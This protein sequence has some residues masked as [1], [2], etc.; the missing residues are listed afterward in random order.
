MGRRSWPFAFGIAACGAG[1]QAHHSIA[2]VYDSTR[3]VTV[4]GRVTEFR[5]VN[6]H[7]FLIIEAADGVGNPQPWQLEMDNRFELAQIGITGGTYKPGDLVIATGSAGRE[8][9]QSLYVRRLD[10]PADGLRYEQI[11][12]R[13]RVS[14]APP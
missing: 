6:P 3:Q 11:G 4:E 10:R 2:S 7:P 5:F 8:Q 9:A 14:G 12:S 13:P 1:A